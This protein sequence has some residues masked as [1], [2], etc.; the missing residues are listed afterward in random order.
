MNRALDAIGG[1]NTGDF[2]LEPANAIKCSIQ[3]GIHRCHLLVRSTG[4]SRKPAVGWRH[5][6][7]FP[8][9]CARLPAKAGTTNKA[10]PVSQPAQQCC[11][12]K[13]AYVSARAV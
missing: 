4:F 9:S 13:Q 7:R 1:I 11:S 12:K 2:F 8:P 5:R 3:A 10:D 6:N